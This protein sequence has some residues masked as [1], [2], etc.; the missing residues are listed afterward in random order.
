MNGI[1]MSL[2]ATERATV[3]PLSGRPFQLTDESSVMTSSLHFLCYQLNFRS[4]K[5]FF[6]FYNCFSFDVDA[7]GSRLAT[8]SSLE[9]NFKIK[10]TNQRWWRV[11][12]RGIRTLRFDKTS[13]FSP[14]LLCCVIS[15]LP[16]LFQLVAFCFLGRTLVN[17]PFSICFLFGSK[18]QD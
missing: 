3:K 16:F 5:G 17:T 18:M 11:L 14:S 15:I 6:R 10:F 12:R 1:L 8:V 13:K 7:A 2:N 4:I 9:M